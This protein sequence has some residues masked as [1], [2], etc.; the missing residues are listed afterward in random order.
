MI[1]DRRC[2]VWTPAGWAAERAWEMAT[3]GPLSVI[4]DLLSEA[5][6]SVRPFTL[7]REASSLP[8]DSTTHAS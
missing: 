2:V 8:P 5:D 7:A 4:N 3:V 6:W 1:S